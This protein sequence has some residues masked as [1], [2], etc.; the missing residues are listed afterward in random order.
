MAL[1]RPCGQTETAGASLSA[2]AALRQPTYS[3]DPKTCVLAILTP[4]CGSLR[5]NLADLML[6]FRHLCCQGLPSPP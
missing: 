2:D 1:V 5:T 6:R 3:S 4:V